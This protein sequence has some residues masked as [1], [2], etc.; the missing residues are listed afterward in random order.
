MNSEL[1]HLLKT[2]SDH[3]ACSDQESLANLLTNLRVVAD[4]LIL[5]FDR[6]D[7]TAG[8]VHEL[9]DDVP[10]CPTI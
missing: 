7:H 9:R 5:D 6:A 10:F 3:E 4:D 1:R 2:N 8:T